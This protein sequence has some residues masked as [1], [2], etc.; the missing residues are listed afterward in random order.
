MEPIS[1]DESESDFYGSE[2]VVARLRNRVRTFDTAKWQRDRQA[3][4]RVRQPLLHGIVPS[5]YPELYNPYAGVSYAWQFAETVEDFLVRLPPATT[6]ATSACPWIYICNPSVRRKNND[7]AQNQTSRGNEDEAPEEEG[8]QLASLIEGGAERLHLLRT[9]TEAARNT[10]QP[11]SRIQK[12]IREE[13]RHA[14]TDILT[15]AHKCRVQAGKWMLFCPRQEVNGVWGVV[16]K[17]TANNELGIAAKVAPRPA[18]GE[19]A[20][21][22]ICVYTADFNDLED[23]AR[24]LERLQELGIANANGPAIFYKPVGTPGSSEPHCTAP[25]TSEEVALGWWFQLLWV[26]DLRETQHYKLPGRA[27]R[28]FHPT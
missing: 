13:K 25:W 27:F 4:N 9:F 28:V 12:G 1:M 17:A 21:R 22:L 3:A 7:E 16:A 15:L 10:A 5:N 8:T 6:E 18:D 14:V 11:P 19:R 24:V 20:H 2:D 23:V 26:R